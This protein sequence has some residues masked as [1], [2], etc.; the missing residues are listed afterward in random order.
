MRPFGWGGRE[1]GRGGR[2][3]W[4]DGDLDVRMRG[5]RGGGRRR[6]VDSAELRLLLLALIGEKAC[7]GYDLI[8]AIEELSGGGYAPSPGIVYPA[9]ALLEDLGQILP[10][11]AEGARKTF[12]ITAAGKAEL[13]SKA[14]AVDALKKRLGA[15]A[16]M[17]RQVHAPIRRAMNNL[18]MVLANTAWNDGQVDPHQVAE[19]IDEAARKIERLG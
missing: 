10:A 18:K 2:G 8:R 4:T 15:I 12:A 7:H 17:D 5:G 13:A 19:C 16:T 11:E 3:G 1:F 6:I 14:T 9:L